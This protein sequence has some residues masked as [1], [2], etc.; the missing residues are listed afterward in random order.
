MYEISFTDDLLNNHK[1]KMP[2]FNFVTGKR[3]ENYIDIVIDDNTMIIMEGLHALNPNLINDHKSE[4]Y[5]IYLS[6][7]ANYIKNKKLLTPAK[8]VRLLRRITRDFYTR[9]YSVLE[10]ITS[11]QNVCDGED[12]WVKPFKNTADYIIDSVHEY[13]LLLYSKYT[14]PIIKELI[15]EDNV[16]SLL[17]KEK[18]E[19]KKALLLRRLNKAKELSI[20]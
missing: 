18:D 16:K 7:N 14:R 2:I 9:G 15:L 10:T 12:K 1:A 20:F 13:E 5:K 19:D 17:D 11:W 4:I 6:L 3:E 8:E